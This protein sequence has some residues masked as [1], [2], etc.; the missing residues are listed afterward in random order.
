M[1]KRKFTWECWDYDLEGY[2]YVVSKDECPDKENFVQYISAEDFGHDDDIGG[3]NPNPE[4]KE[5]WCSFQC[6]SDWD[7]G[8]YRNGG[9]IVEEGT[10][11]PKYGRGWFPVWISRRDDVLGEL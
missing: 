3:L 2:A 1:S 4:I 6:R 9:Y 11:K 8:S 7:D 5:G 10:E